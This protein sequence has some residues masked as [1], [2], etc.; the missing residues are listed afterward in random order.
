[1]KL[2]MGLATEYITKQHEFMLA[3]KEDLGDAFNNA[4]AAAA[5]LVAVTLGGIDEPTRRLVFDIALT[6]A[7][8]ALRKR[9]EENGHSPVGQKPN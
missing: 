2:W 1:M 5:Y 7:F 6:N 9:K 8:T 3:H 4:V